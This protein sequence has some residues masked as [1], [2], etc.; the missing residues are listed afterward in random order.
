MKIAEITSL[1]GAYN[2]TEGTLNALGSPESMWVQGARAM[3]RTDVV[4]PPLT[5]LPILDLTR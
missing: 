5:D 4:E 2:C 3:G 1:T